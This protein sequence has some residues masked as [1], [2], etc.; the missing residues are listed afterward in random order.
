MLI[1]RDGTVPSVDRSARIAPTAV[2]VGDVHVGAD[3][4]VGHGTLIES[5]GPAVTIGR[6]SVI[7]QNAVIRSVGGG[8][9]GLPVFPTWIGDSALIGP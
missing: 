5:T 1:E 2:L 9:A 7:M 8:S 6:A 4:Y 3:T